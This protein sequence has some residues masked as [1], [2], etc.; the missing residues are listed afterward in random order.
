[1]YTRFCVECEKEVCG[2]I[3]TFIF[4]LK[5]SK[6]MPEIVYLACVH[7]IFCCQPMNGKTNYIHTEI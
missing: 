3:S 4:S 1:M 5:K 7:S 2:D 6:R